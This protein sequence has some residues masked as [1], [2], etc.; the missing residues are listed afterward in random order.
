MTRTEQLVDLP[1][2]VEDLEGDVGVEVTAM[3]EGV[4]VDLLEVQAIVA[5]AAGVPRVDTMNTTRVDL[6]EVMEAAI[7]VDSRI[8]RV[9]TEWNTHNRELGDMDLLV[10][11]KLIQAEGSGVLDKICSK[12]K[13]GPNKDTRFR[14]Q[15]VGSCTGRKI[16]AKRIIT[17][18][19]A[20]LRSGSALRTG[21]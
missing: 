12:R 2:L 10:V 7:L 19:E 18:T 13:F 9:D 5:R 21:R 15:T 8:T 11:S 4:E 1:Q 20:T 3:V 17:I 14:V 6:Q 16:Q